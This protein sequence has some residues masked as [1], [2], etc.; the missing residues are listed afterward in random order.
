MDGMDTN[1]TAERFFAKAHPEPNTGCWLWGG[2]LTTRGYGQLRGHGGQGSKVEEA[3]RVSWLLHHGQIP[4][5]LLVCHRCDVRH[6]VNP[7]H[8]FLGTPKDN[9]DDMWRKGR[10]TIRRGEA[11][12]HARPTDDAVRT[13]RTRRAGGETIAALAAEYGV[14]G[15]TI[16]HAGAGRTWTHVGGP[17][18]PRRHRWGHGTTPLQCQNAGCGWM[19]QSATTQRY[20]RAGVLQRFDRMHPAP[21]CEGKQ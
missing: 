21:P 11:T 6:C 5:G 3:H 18:T 14:S 16:Q 17:V 4:S 20:S 10:G 9:A 12:G 2:A 7:D 15:A 1:T 8:L 19:R 13:I